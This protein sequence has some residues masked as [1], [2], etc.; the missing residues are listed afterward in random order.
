MM[1]KMNFYQYNGEN[2]LG[3]ILNHISFQWHRVPRC[4]H[5]VTQSHWM[6][7]THQIEKWNLLQQIIIIA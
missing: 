5:M 1:T 6:Q 2:S 7:Y 4:D 3:H